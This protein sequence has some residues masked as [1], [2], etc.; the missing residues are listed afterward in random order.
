MTKKYNSVLL[1]IDNTLTDL[2][3]T[4]DIMAEEFGVEAVTT[5]D[6]HSFTL[7]DAY[8]VTSDQEAEFWIENE[9]RLTQ[10]SV[11]EV[12]R[13]KRM[14][15]DYTHE[16]TVIH[17]V[18]MRPEEMYEATFHWLRAN[19]IHFDHLICLGQDSK[20]DYAMHFGI[21]A[22]FEDNPDF[23]DEVNEKSLNDE[24]DLFVI[25]Y[26]YNQHV[27]NAVRLDRETGRVL[28]PE[29]VW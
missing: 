12:E 6:I 26:P 15:D 14:L 7:A 28:Q 21:E 5:N 2:Q 1:D 19:N 3:P 27:T 25:D 13:V 11:L 16:D 24:F 10:E 29:P 4:L 17:V 18:T 22:L 23:F 8:N 20:V 9:L